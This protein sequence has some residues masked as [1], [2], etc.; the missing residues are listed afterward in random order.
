MPVLVRG[1]AR[2][3]G[4]LERALPASARYQR[5]RGTKSSNYVPEGVVLDDA[6]TVVARVS[7]N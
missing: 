1:L 3:N 5:Y 7:Y 4:N 2:L 6:G